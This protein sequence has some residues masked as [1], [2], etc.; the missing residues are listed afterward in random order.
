M[1]KEHIF[2]FKDTLIAFIPFMIAVILVLYI[3]PM[4]NL[5]FDIRVFSAGMVY[6]ILLFLCVIEGVSCFPAVRFDEK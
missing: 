2:E 1:G 4:I 6:S 5:Y 3:P